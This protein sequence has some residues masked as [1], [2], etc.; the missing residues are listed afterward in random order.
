MMNFT[1]VV[2]ASAMPPPP[3]LTSFTPYTQAK[4]L[5]AV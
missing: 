3:I 4:S 5:S 2:N 1:P